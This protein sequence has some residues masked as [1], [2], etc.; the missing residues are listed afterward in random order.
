MISNNKKIYFAGPLFNNAELEFN[1]KLTEKLENLGYEVFLPQRDGIENK[2]LDEMG[3]VKVE[4]TRPHI[5][6]DQREAAIFAID[7]DKVFEADIFLFIL[8]GRI[9]DEGACLELG[10]AYT[11][12]YFGHAKNKI[13]IGLHTDARA[14]FISSKINCM[15]SVPLDKIFSNTP[16][17]LDFFKDLNQNQFLNINPSKINNLSL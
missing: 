4:V 8:D 1:V 16:D 15:V 12:R 7:R 9:P 10:L 17:L 13:L 5:T 14:A 6:I 11:Q 3:Q 2:Y